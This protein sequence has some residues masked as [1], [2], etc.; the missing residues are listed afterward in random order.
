M[1]YGNKNIQMQITLRAT[2]AWENRSADQ[3]CSADLID[4]SYVAE[5]S[6][7]TPCKSILHLSL[8]QINTGTKSAT[9]AVTHADKQKKTKYT[10]LSISNIYM[11]SIYNSYVTGTWLN[12]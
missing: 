2:R 12:K 3:L 1:S 7:H 10:N 6:C 4:P 9:V 8:L 5:A 11:R